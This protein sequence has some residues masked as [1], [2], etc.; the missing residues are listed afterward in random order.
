[1]GGRS[2]S[3]ASLQRAMDAASRLGSTE[4][5]LREGPRQF[6]LLAA[7]VARGQFDPVTHWEEFLQALWEQVDAGFGLSVDE[8]SYLAVPSPWFD[9]PDDPDVV[10]WASRRKSARD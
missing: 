3:T 1:M 6:F 5:E 7:E 8:D 9:E 10:V 2:V 4:R